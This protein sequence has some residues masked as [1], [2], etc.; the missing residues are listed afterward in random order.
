MNFV[1]QIFKNSFV[2]LQYTFIVIRSSIKFVKSLF[3]SFKLIRI[4]NIS[5]F[6]LHKISQL[7]KEKKN[8]MLTYKI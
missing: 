3:S 4:P 7:K 6:Y 8:W 2:L 5:D 1:L